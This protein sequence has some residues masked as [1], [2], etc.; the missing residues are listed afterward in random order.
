MSVREQRSTSEGLELHDDDD[1]VEEVAA[2]DPNPQQHQ[3]S[4]GLAGFKEGDD[5]TVTTT[6]VVEPVELA[7]LETPVSHAADR[8]LGQKE[9]R[10][11]SAF[12]MFMYDYL[13]LTT[14]KVVLDRIAKH[15]DTKISFADFAIKVNRRNKMQKRVLLITEHAIYNMEP[16]NYKIKRRIE[17]SKL[18]SI[19]L[20]TLPDNFFC[21]HVSQEYDYLMVSG[22]KVEIVTVLRMNYNNLTQKVL[23]INFSDSFEYQIGTG[24][25]RQIQ[26]TRVDGGVSTQI[27]DKKA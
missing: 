5:L 21:I 11:S 4:L 16:A 18:K 27:F 20:S 24:S 23:E 15:G 7:I 3:E 25:S 2:P 26:F 13:S 8:F 10:N 12:K 1:H 9:R 19:S 22:R 17:I 6:A 14:N